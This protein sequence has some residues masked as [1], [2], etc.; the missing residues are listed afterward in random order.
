MD[1]SKL[2]DEVLIRL[3]AADNVDSLNELCDTYH[4]IIHQEFERVAFHS[5]CP[6]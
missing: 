5:L 3:I 6:V 4:L 2:D 1:Y